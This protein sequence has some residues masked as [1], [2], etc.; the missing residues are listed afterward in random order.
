M[1]VTYDRQNIF[2]VQA[3]GSICWLVVMDTLLSFLQSRQHKLWVN[4]KKV[5][6]GFNFLNLSSSV[7]GVAYLTSTLYQSCFE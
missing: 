5:K 3:I 1:I 4:L 6:T 7:F 2:T